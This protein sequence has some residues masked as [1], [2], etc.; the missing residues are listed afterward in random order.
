M[1]LE[2]RPWK[3][4]RGAA[5]GFRPRKSAPNTAVQR[6]A[7][8][9]RK[10]VP[11]RHYQAPGASSSLSLPELSPVRATALMGF[12]AAPRRAAP[13]TRERGSDTLSP[14]NAAVTRSARTYC[15]TPSH[16]RRDQIRHYADPLSR[17]TEQ[18]QLREVCSCTNLTP[19][20]AASSPGSLTHPRQPLTSRRIASLAKPLVL[21]GGSRKTH[22][23]SAKDPQKS[24]PSQ[25]R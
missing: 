3:A 23:P 4:G 15:M 5:T 6:G 8:S 11:F 1:L 21:P 9:V 24:C 10:Q 13:S 20:P 25:D 22:G 7:P 17:P 12:T 18:P 14:G 19:L 2:L 16:R